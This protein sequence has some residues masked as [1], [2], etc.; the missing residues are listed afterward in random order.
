M[1]G[2]LCQRAIQKLRS[3]LRWLQYQRSS[4]PVHDGR[5]F[6]LSLVEILVAI[7]ELTSLDDIRIATAGCAGGNNQQTR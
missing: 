6:V 1:G 4:A 5:I 3:V 7:L 2:A